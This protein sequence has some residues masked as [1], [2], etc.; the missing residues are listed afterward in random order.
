MRCDTWAD[1]D[2]LLGFLVTPALALGVW[3]TFAARRRLGRSNRRMITAWSAAQ[4]VILA[5]MHLPPIQ[6]ETCQFTDE[7]RHLD[8]RAKAEA[9]QRAHPGCRWV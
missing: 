3:T 5:S 6:S 1:A 9:Y 4:L 2:F 8:I 7:I